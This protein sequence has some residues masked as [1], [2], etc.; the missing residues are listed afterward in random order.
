MDGTPTVLSPGN[1]LAKNRQSEAPLVENLRRVEAEHD[2]ARGQRYEVSTAVTPSAVRGVMLTAVAF[3][4][5][6]VADDEVDASDT[7]DVDLRAQ[8]DMGIHCSHSK[9][10]LESRLGS[11]VKERDE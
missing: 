6:S 11:R 8:A 5:Q 2:V 9:G 1:Q 10:G 3:D 7:R 4:Q